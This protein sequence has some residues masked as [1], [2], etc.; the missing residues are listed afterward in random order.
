MTRIQLSRYLVRGC[1]M[2][3][4]VAAGISTCEAQEDGTSY[5]GS[6][7]WL[8]QDDAAK[9]CGL[10]AENAAALRVFA[11][12]RTTEGKEQRGLWICGA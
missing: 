8:L 12:Q 10:S 9:L 3:S 6:L 11:T 4:V 7:H 5:V 1:M 2:L